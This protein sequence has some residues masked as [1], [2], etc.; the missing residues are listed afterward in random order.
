VSTKILS[1]AEA[2]NLIPDG[3]TVA[4]GGFVGIG[5]PEALT[6]ALEARFLATGQPRD[7][8]LVYAA[9]QGDGQTRGM[10]HLAHAGLLKRV[11][12]G[13]WNL[14]PKLGQLALSNTIEAYNLPQG[15]ITHLY[16]DIAAGKPGTITHIGLHTFV[17]PRLGG[18][19]LNARTTED[20]VEVLW[21]AGREW[22]FY[23]AFP[24]TVGLIRG[25]TADEHGNIRMEREALTLENLSIAQAARNCGGR[26]LAQVERV[27]A[28][29]QL[30]PKDVQVPGIL[31]DAIIIAPPEQ[32]WQTFAESFNPA[33]VAPPT[34][35]PITLP[36]RPLDE[37]KIIARRAALELFP[38]AVLN[39]GIGLPED[40]ALIANEAGVLN[41]IVITVEAGCIG[42]LPAS[43]L[44]FG[45]ARHPEAI[46]DQPYQ[47]DF[48][49]GGGLDLAF[50]GMV[51]VDLEGNVNVSRLGGRLMGAG[52]FINISQTAKR[53]V[54]CGTFT[55]GNLVVRPNLASGELRIEQE[56]AYPKFVEQ[57]EH[58]TFSGGWAQQRGQAVLYITERAIFALEGGGLILR[59]IAPGVDLERDV[60]SQMEFRPGIAPDLREMDR[61]FFRPEVMGLANEFRA[62]G[63]IS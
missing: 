45:A 9:G 38:E 23:H 62:R 11:V 28:V 56:G 29:G 27:V 2:V 16:R 34:G 17:D 43:G 49:D 37:R 52:G 12:G 41:D 48:Y 13:H 4:S 1:A 35:G 10:N 19:R 21:L 5:H 22:L 24:I 18:G 63:Q 6:A 8:T 59:E 33:Y 60:L 32:H 42:G 3:A 61:R 14:A 44:S 46:V 25:T 20:L 26:V 30:D 51:Q 39:L 40:I 55:A 31:V 50:L 7:L 54:F 47:F 15:V 58:V 36:S 53:I 57:V